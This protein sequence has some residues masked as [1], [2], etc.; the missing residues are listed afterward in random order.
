MG[1][2][3]FAVREWKTRN[4]GRGV[5]VF[6]T[7][8]S[9]SVLFIGRGGFQYEDIH[10]PL[11]SVGPEAQKLEIATAIWRCKSVKRKDRLK[12]PGAGL[13]ASPDQLKGKWPHLAEFLTSAVYEDGTPREAPTLTLWCSGGLWRLTLKDRA[14]Q[15]VMWLSSEKLLEVVALAEQYCL[16]EEAPWRVDDYSPEHGKRKKGLR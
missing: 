10:M 14:E 1:R 4:F 7:E 6:V 3:V 8:S 15:M 9:A 5:R 12:T 2:C 13:H 11:V 16:E